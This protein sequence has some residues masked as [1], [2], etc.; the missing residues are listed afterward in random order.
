MAVK[1]ENIHG[2]WL[3]F[4]EELREGVRY[5]RDDLQQREAKTLFDAARFDGTAEFE[6]DQD[7]DWSLIYNRQKGNYTLIR[8][9]RE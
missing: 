9:Q 6:D 1:K 3:I 5:L 2:F 8:R 4:E 7:R